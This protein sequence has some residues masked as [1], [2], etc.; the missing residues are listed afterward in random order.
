MQ[1]S[2]H[3]N[4]HALSK[5]TSKLSRLPEKITLSRVS[6]KENPVSIREI[7]RLQFESI[8]FAVEKQMEPQMFY[9]MDYWARAAD[10]AGKFLST[11]LHCQTDS[12]AGKS[13]LD[14]SPSCL[15]FSWLLPD[16]LCQVTSIWNLAC[17][18]LWSRIWLLQ[19]VTTNIPSAESKHHF[20][21]PL[22][23][24]INFRGLL[25]LKN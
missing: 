3:P 5:S 10:S 12:V 22:D 15:K 13:C 7:R 23:H 8:E 14:P 18:V 17:S 2:L 24:W 19:Y 9:W 25:W 21:R 4:P 16:L 11:A 20:S 1:F 6:S